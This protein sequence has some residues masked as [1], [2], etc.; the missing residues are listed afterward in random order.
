MC[1]L[2]LVTKKSLEPNGFPGEFYQTF[3]EEIQIQKEEKFTKSFY[4]ANISLIPKPNQT[5]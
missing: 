2:K 3:E 4:E 1:G 5:S